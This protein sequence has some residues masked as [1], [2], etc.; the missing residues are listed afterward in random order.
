MMQVLL[1]IAFDPELDPEPAER[2]THQ[3]RA[4]IAELDI[5]SVGPAP[6]ATVPDGAKGNEAVA[7]GAV[8]VALSASA[9]AITAILFVRRR[10]RGQ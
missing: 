4:E 10:R 1:S 3:L 9:V 6:A 5:E 7:L 2:L 8:V